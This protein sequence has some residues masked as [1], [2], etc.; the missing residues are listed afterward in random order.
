MVEDGD[1]HQMQS[2]C[3]ATYSGPAAGTSMRQGTFTAGVKTGRGGRTLHRTPSNG[4]S[5]AHGEFRNG[6]E[7]TA[8]LGGGACLD[9]HDQPASWS[10]TFEMATFMVGDATF[11][12]TTEVNFGGGATDT[13]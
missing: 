1:V 2:R 3:T 6:I 8:N 12:S 11:D 10:V 5:S 7:W 9:R 4:S 13:G